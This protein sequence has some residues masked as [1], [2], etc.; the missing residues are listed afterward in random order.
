MSDSLLK[1]AAAGTNIG[2]GGQVFH[3]AFF[4][5]E[6]R[7]LLMKLTN[8]LLRTKIQEIEL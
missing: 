8:S 7:A 1:Y 6:R 2:L 4:G 3:P 5:E